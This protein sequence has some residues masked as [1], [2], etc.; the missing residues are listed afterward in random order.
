M[1]RN[2]RVGP[3]GRTPIS[4]LEKENKDPEDESKE[5]KK[6]LSSRG[7]KVA[8]DE[9]LFPLVEFFTHQGKEIV[10]VVREEFRVE[11][12]EGKALARRVQVRCLV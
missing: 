8:K 11:D 9:D 7:G 4:I 5:D 12:N 2:V 1:V 10:L 6:P 3:D